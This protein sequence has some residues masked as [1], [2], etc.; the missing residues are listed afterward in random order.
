MRWQ[1]LTDMNSP[2]R[3]ITLLIG[4]VGLVAIA[5]VPA[6]VGLVP[7]P[8]H[9]VLQLPPWTSVAPDCCAGASHA[10]FGDIATQFYPWHMRLN[11]MIGSL[12]LPIWNHHILMGTPL[13]AESTPGVFFP[14]NLLHAVL[15]APAAWT[16]G[17]VLRYLVVAFTTAL[18]ARRLGLSIAGT[19]VAAVAFTFCG[20]TVA[21]NGRP[22]L[23]SA[24]WLPLML[25]CVDRLAER[26][27]ATRLVLLALSFA[28]AVLGGHPEVAAQVIFLACLFG[29][30]RGLTVSGRRLQFA[31]AYL[32]AAL[33][34]VGLA[35]MQVLPTAE[36][37]PH[38]DRDLSMRWGTFD[39]TQARGLISRDVSRH[40]NVDGVF[41]PEAASY[42]GVVTI[43][44]AC[45]ALLWGRRRD[46]VAMLV[47]GL[48]AFGI[49]FGVPPLSWGVEYIPIINALPNTRFL[50]GVNVALA[51]L[52]GVGLSAI[53]SRLV[54]RGRFG[55]RAVGAA[56]LVVVLLVGIEM[57]TYMRPYMP[58]VPAS[59]IFPSN[60][61]FDFLQREAGTSHRVASVDVT[62]G[63]NFEIP[64]GLTTASGYDFPTRRP[65]SFLSRFSSGAGAIS[66]DSSKLAELPA[67]A[68]DLTG[69]R[70]LVATE[71]NA[72]VAR[73][74]SQ[75][76]RFRP[77]FKDG[78]VTVFAHD[79]GIPLVSLF[80]PSSIRV[81]NDESSQLARLF[82]TDFDP[83]REIV[84]SDPAETFHGTTG[85]A[86]T[87]SATVV[88]RGGSFIEIA[89]ETTGPSVLYLNETFY[90]GFS[91]SVNGAP[92]ELLRANYA[93]S[94]VA[95]NPGVHLVRVSYVTPGLRVGLAIG[96]VAWLVACGIL[97]VRVREIV[98]RQRCGSSTAP[99]IHT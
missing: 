80:E 27:S 99:K 58:W 78:M 43:A 55:P 91:V 16:I 53:V 13:L 3:F 70:F 85:P 56:A 2:Q 31:T 4:L 18:F 87:N 68:L 40:P 38:L 75:P 26:Q 41:I 90:D 57:V 79:S 28:L 45:V 39:W 9:V 65:L 67:G 64:Y 60:P 29:V 82:A 19:A 89:A 11:A 95:L 50:V 69:T 62:Y 74:S 59:S 7:F 37:L 72:S 92:A 54:G 52:A 81:I 20:W 73:L 24:M 15:P 47:V 21:F 17:F 23:D 35:A 98:R 94:A 5:C 12:D 51:V 32:G 97:A 1:R 48:V 22:H 88:R 76:D 36:W 93:F 33:L 44:L 46:V 61:T 83:S 30:C 77:V 71:W 34:A 25:W 14:L 96:V 66:F 6:L 8:A 86:T 84:L 10:E 49:V 42:A 63:S